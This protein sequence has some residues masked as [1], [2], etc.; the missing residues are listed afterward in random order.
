VYVLKPGAIE[1]V[2]IIFG[3]VA[4]HVVQLPVDFLFE[5]VTLKATENELCEFVCPLCLI[6]SGGKVRRREISRRELGRIA[7]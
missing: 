3:T 5:S 6:F 2:Q 4:K 1:A 7:I